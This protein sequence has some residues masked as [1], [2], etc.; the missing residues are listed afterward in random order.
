M[1]YEAVMG[2]EVHAQLLTESKIFCG[3]STKFG[4]PPNTHVCPVCLGMPGVLPVLNERVVEF[5]IR[6]GLATNCAVQPKSI[7]ARKNYF[8]PDLPKDYQI[9]QYELPICLDGWLDIQVEGQEKRRI[10][11]TRIHMEEDA[12]KLI[13]DPAQ[14]VS[15]VDYNRTG[16]PLMEIVSEPDLRTPAEAG[17][18]LRALRDILVYLEVCDGN[19]EEGSF[20]CDANVSLRP[21]GQKELGTKAELK[22]MNSFRGVER[23][24]EY[25]IRR[26]RAI[27]D[28]G[29]KVKQETRLWD[30]DQGKSFGMRGKEEAH[31]Y[32][33]MPDPDLLP[34]LVDEAWIER[35]RA[36]LPE[37]PEAKRRRLVAEHG[38]SEYDAGV[39]TASKAMADY[40]EAAVAAGA[41]AKAAANWVT[42][43]LVGALKAQ[44][45]EIG[46]TPISP[47]GLAGLIKLIE[48]GTISGKMAKEVFADM[49]GTGEAA[50]AIVKKKGLTQVS[51]EGELESML[52]EIFAANPAEVEA[53]K[54]GKKKLMGFFVGQV[55]QK[56]KGQANPKLVNQLIN[57]LLGG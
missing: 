1:E 52:Q 8:Y 23:A 4:A 31:D 46:Q 11:I 17:A 33:Y 20:R 19:M 2:L 16:V 5:T 10:G 15:Y 35:V 7:W 38:L 6:A 29:G 34:L 47:E 40:Y 43:D 42:S 57:K 28:E 30:P 41:P 36:G 56:T 48:A 32:R 50:E 27:L 9:S 44:S 39:L 51:D 55:M 13:H 14:P 45:L 53:F 3:C 22:N 49:M 25:E 37:L 21:V 24:L 54:G 26:Q 12:G 18:Y